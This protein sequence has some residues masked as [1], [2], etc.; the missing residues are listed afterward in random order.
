MTL[1]K[2][3]YPAPLGPIKTVIEPFSICIVALLTAV[4]PPKFF[5]TLLIFN[6]IDLFFYNCNEDQYLITNQMKS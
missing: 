4:N 2:V 3:V 5:C 6:I 1:N